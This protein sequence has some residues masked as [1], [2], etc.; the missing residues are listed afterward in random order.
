MHKDKEAKKAYE[1]NWYNTIG[2][3]K[4]LEANKRWSE[5]KADEFKKIKSTLRCNRCGESHIACLDFHHLDQSKKDGNIST[6]VRRCSSEKLLEE[7]SKCEILCA[8][9]HRK[10]HYKQAS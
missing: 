4:R 5:K 7:I 9:C 10:E 1:R 3:E 6:L 8:N 2:K